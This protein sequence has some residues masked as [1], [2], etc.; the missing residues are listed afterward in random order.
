MLVVTVITATLCVLGNRATAQ[1]NQGGGRQRQRGNFDPAQFQQR[2]MDRYRERLELTDDAEWKAVQPLIQNVLDAR[3]AL[4]GG[5][6][7]G[8]FGRGGRRGGGDNNAS[9]QGQTRPPRRTNPATE[10]LQKAIDSKAPAPEMKT[11]LA[12]YQDYRKA[13]QAEL[14]K[15]Q[16]A[17]R[18]VL[19]ARQEAI[20]T[21]SGLL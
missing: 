21:V 1:T 6:G 8:F 18:A 5:G 10:D 9:D 15:A 20:A 16:D 2:M 7:P 12:R 19:T 17:L 13:K 3:M 14:E 11:A 4:R